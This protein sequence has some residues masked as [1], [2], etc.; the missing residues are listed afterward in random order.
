MA[1]R[2]Y[3]IA[4]H[5]QL[6]AFLFWTDN[7]KE[8]KKCCS[9]HLFVL[10]ASSQNCAPHIPIHTIVKKKKRCHAMIYT[11]FS[12]FEIS[13]DT[14][15]VNGELQSTSKLSNVTMISKMFLSSCATWCAISCPIPSP[16]PP[17]TWHPSYHLISV[18]QRQEQTERKQMLLLFLNPHS[19]QTSC[20][21]SVTCFN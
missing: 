19:Y 3:G 7:V 16:Q 2:L 20:S 6:I 18:S 9:C 21:L 12:L 11:F 14:Q 13:G 10:S 8:R 15:N 1:N 5:R 17:A 4:S